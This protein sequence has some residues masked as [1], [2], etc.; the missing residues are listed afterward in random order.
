MQP[1]LENTEDSY[2]V[3][4]VNKT[5]T[6]KHW[7]YGLTIFA[8]MSENDV[9]CLLEKVTIFNGRRLNVIVRGRLP[10]GHGCKERGHFKKKFASKQNRQKLKNR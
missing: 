4:I 3:D 2:E 7:G 1:F 10:L 8:M 9:R 5:E 6:V